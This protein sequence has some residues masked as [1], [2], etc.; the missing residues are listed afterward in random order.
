M[1]SVPSLGYFEPRSD[2]SEQVVPLHRLDIHL[3]PEWLDQ[4]LDPCFFSWG[5]SILLSTMA[6]SI[7]ILTNGVKHGQIWLLT[8]STIL[9]VKVEK[10]FEL[11]VRRSGLYSHLLNPPVK[12]SWLQD[13]VYLSLNFLI[14]IST[15][16]SQ[17]AL[18][19]LTWSNKRNN[20]ALC[21]LGRSPWILLKSYQWWVL[22]L[23][24]ASNN[25]K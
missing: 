13:M 17:P 22:T 8:L 23:W 6:V 1:W 2:K 16:M 10:S 11:D 21:H 9:S 20:Y 19:S 5:R 18:P 12:E 7:C 4:T 15:V 3:E 14:C 24:N 25:Y